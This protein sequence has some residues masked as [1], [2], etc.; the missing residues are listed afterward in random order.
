LAII[1]VKGEMVDDKDR[2]DA[3]CA[4]V[5]GNGKMRV[6]MRVGEPRQLESKQLLTTS[7]QAIMD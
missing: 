1:I 6:E 5:G 7:K 3:W 2:R 4:R